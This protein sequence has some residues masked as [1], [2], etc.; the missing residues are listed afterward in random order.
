[1]KTGSFLPIKNRCILARWVPPAAAAP[2]DTPG[3]ARWLLQACAQTTTTPTSEGADL[4]QQ[5][6]GHR[7]LAIGW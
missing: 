3:P 2:L 7:L 6:P 1:M 4:D 5:A